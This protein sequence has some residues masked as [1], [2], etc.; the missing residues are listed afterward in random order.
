MDRIAVEPR[1]DWQSQAEAQ[2]FVFHTMHGAPYWD[3]TRAYRFSLAE[4]E[5][6]IEDPTAMLERMAYAVVERA[7]T[8]PG[9]LDRLRIPEDFHDLVR[10][11]WRRGDKNLYGRFDFAYGAGGPAKLLEYNADTPTSLFESAVF[12]WIWLEQMMERG[13]VPKGADQFNS[14]H[15]RL[16]DAFGRF[17]ISPRPLHLAAV[18]SSAEDRGTVEYLADCAAQAGIE[19]R[20]IDIAAIGVDGAGRFTDLDDAVI[21]HLFKL[22]PWEFMVQEPFGRHLMA[23]RTT[24]IEPAWKMV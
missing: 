18:T 12:Q 19:T 20:L 21:T 22:Y 24:V 11:S 13:D 7:V 5:A 15:E 16:I 23:D 3:E 10:A 1:P 2:G 4:I 17:G 8:E 14:L 6:E 9:L